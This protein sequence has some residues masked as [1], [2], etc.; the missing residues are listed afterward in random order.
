MQAGD[1]VGLKYSMQ[2][3]E[4]A[5]FERSVMRLGKYADAEMGFEVLNQ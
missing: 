2:S 5:E 3:L 4:K 1:E